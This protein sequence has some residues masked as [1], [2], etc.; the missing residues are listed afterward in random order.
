MSKN[1]QKFTGSA[2]I[3][4]DERDVMRQ[5]FE[6]KIASPAQESAW[7]VLWKMVAFELKQILE[8]MTIQIKHEINKTIYNQVQSGTPE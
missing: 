5:C 4:N 8:Y 3:R 6:K 7:D 2:S 1:L